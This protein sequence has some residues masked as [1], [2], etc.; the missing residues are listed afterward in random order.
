MGYLKTGAKV[1][2][3]FRGCNSCPTA[4]EAV[5]RKCPFGNDESEDKVGLK[6]GKSGVE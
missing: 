2:H 5:S 1:I 3:F 4:R 6:W